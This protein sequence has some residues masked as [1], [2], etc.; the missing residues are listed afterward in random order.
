[1][2]SASGPGSQESAPLPPIVGR[3]DELGALTNAL[4]V[5]LDGKGSLWVLAGAPGIG[6]TRVAQEVAVYARSRGAAVAVGRCTEDEGSPP[7]LPFVEALGAAIP[8]SDTQSAGLSAEHAGVI[9]KLLP[10]TIGPQHVPGASQEISPETERYLLFQ[11]VTALL[12]NLARE[13]GLA[14]LLEDLHWADRP[15]LLLLQHLARQLDGSKVLVLGTFR[16]VEVDAKHPLSVILSNLRREAACQ[17]LAVDGLSEEQIKAIVE[18]VARPGA[19]AGLVRALHRQA[20]GNPFFIKEMVLHLMKLGVIYQEDSGWASE[21]NLDEIGLPESV[22]DA[23]GRRLA[24]LSDRCRFLLRQAAVVGEKV[25]HSLLAEV[26]GHGPDDLLDLM[27]EAL[28]ARL[29]LEPPGREAAYAFSHALT[30][31]TLLEELSRA[32]RQRL[33][34]E[35]ALAME[36]LDRANLQPHMSELAYHFYE[37]APLGQPGKAVLYARRAADAAAAALGYEEA[38]RFYDMA[39]QALDLSDSIDKD[40]RCELLLALGDAEMSSGRVDTAREVFDKAADCARALRSPE[41]LARAAIGSGGAWIYGGEAVVKLLEEAASLRGDDQNLRIR[42]LTRLVWE[43]GAQGLGYDPQAH[44]RRLALSHA[45]LEAARLLDDPAALAH[46]LRAR[47]DALWGPDNTEERLEVATEAQCLAENTGLIDVELEARHASIGNLMELGKVADAVA[48]FDVYAKSADRLKQPIYL[49]HALVIRAKL[50]LHKGELQLAERLSAEALAMGQRAGYPAV[51]TVGVQLFALR[52]EQGRLDEL[53]ASA[54]GIVEVYPTVP[55]FAASLAAL[56]MEIEREADARSVFERLAG[57]GFE[58]IPRDWFWLISMSLLSQV[59][60]YLRDARRAA[61]LYQL[62]LPFAPRNVCVV[63]ILSTG[64]ASRSLGLLAAT[65]C[66][67]EEAERHYEDALELNARMGAKPAYAWT[68]YD[69]AQMLVARR[70]QGDRR[71]AYA[72]LTQAAGTARDLG[73]RRL[74]DRVTG[75][76]ESRRSLTPVYPDGLTRRE[77]DVLRL[78]AGGFSNSEISQ[79]LVLSIRTV[80]RH[81]TNVYNKIQARGRADATAYA[82]SHGLAS[83][84]SQAAV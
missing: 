60:A 78:I 15:S 80:E 9:G 29:V 39:L 4:D 6:K 21:L 69:Y 63:N 35:V 31:Q 59:C 12:R 22:K 66:R 50:A 33:H 76:L 30:R 57:E 75:L 72:L 73:L 42:V 44:E 52:R 48:E 53:E 61:T 19:P 18:T 2:E 26:S 14:L 20:D 3:D 16:D 37:A 23:V 13:T 68:Q 32:R 62:L 77:V 45:A 24:L 79:E 67:W 8:E 28:A 54:R 71:K 40:V 27:D 10:Q 64:S 81:V 65:M 74:E 38:A 11:A 56:Y 1:M 36:R 55:G 82:L 17:R 41:Q 43:L 49:F 25:R 7:Y 84:R 47:H 51:R 83:P 46:A 34:R 58:A 5:A 70:H